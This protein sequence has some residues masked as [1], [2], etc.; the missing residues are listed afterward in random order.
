MTVKKRGH[1]QASLWLLQDIGAGSGLTVQL[2]IDALFL[3]I[4]Y[5]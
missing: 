4:S 3:K 2:E 1:L 5:F